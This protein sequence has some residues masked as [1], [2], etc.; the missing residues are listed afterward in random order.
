M[1][2]RRD[3]PKVPALQGHPAGHTWPGARYLPSYH[4]SGTLRR[5]AWERYV[6]AALLTGADVWMLERAEAS[7]L[8][9][10]IGALRRYR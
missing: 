6:R 1:P 8:A 9:D 7:G 2:T 3:R 10:G 4:L 5:L